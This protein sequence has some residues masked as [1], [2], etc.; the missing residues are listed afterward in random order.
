[1]RAN[2][3]FER[4]G[5]RFLSNH[6]SAAKGQVHVGNCP[7][8]NQPSRVCTQSLSMPDCE[9]NKPN[10]VCVLAEASS[11]VEPSSNDRAR[12]STR[13]PSENIPSRKAHPSRSAQENSRS[14]PEIR[15][16][17]EEA[18]SVTKEAT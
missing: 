11:L 5:L 14:W 6:T 7:V 1:M 16:Y 3:I 9:P 8:G 10:L 15:Y 12:H 17:L 4:A 2:F 18:R 13:A